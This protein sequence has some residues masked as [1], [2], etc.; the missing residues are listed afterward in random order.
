MSNASTSSILQEVQPRKPWVNRSQ[1]VREMVK[2]TLI[3][4][5]IAIAIVLFTGLAGPLGFYFSFVLAFIVVSFIDGMRHDKVKAIDKVMTTLVTAGFAT[6]FIPW[7]SIL[8]TVFQRGA[9]AIYFGYF[10]HDMSYT[11]ADDELGMGGLSHALVGSLLILLMASII[12]IPF[13]I[14]TALYITEVKGKLSGLV[15]VI[16]QSMSGVPSIVAG[17]FVYAVVVSR[18]SFSGVAGAI[19]LS[20]LMLPTVAR[21]SEEVLKLVPDDLRSSAYALGASQMATTFR[22]VLPT[23]RS[24]LI[25]ASMLGLARVAG[26]TAP[27]ILTAYYSAVYSL[28]VTGQPLASLPMYI[29]QN[30]STGTDT[31]LTRAWG[32]AAVLLSFIFILFIIARIAGRGSRK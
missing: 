7:A 28:K 10:T 22:I 25:T 18:Y 30:F 13:G 23:A 9:S 32:G 2:P 20:I 17:L 15:R 24:G 27:L 5:I 12:A 26:E 6:A 29:F 1:S 16:V 4:G 8:F 21:T 11:S 31:A 14:V 3:A 19:A